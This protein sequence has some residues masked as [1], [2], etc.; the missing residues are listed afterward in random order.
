MRRITTILVSSLVALPMWAQTQ[1]NCKLGSDGFR[2]RGLY[3]LVNGG[4][5]R[6]TLDQPQDFSNLNQNSYTYGGEVGYL[7]TPN[8]GLDIG[9]NRLPTFHLPLVYLGFKL[10][11]IKTDFFQTYG[12]VKLRIPLKN[13]RTS[14]F[15]ELG[16]ATVHADLPEIDLGSSTVNVT[17]D[18]PYFAFGVDYQFGKAFF[19]DT[20]SSLVPT[21][22]YTIYT[23]T[24]GVGY[25]FQ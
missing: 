13:K 6:Q 10:G 18:G 11:Q 5:V 14:L 15:A 2:T 12:A 3:I 17:E 8:F 16:V 9:F 1:C 19:L 22:N 23:V 24:I 20:E 25:I 7:F 21:K 4:F